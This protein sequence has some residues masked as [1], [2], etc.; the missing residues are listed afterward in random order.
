MSSTTAVES[1]PAECPASGPARLQLFST[2][3]SSS[4][5]GDDYKDRL[6]QVAK[7]SEQAGCT[8]SLIYTDNSLVDPWIV[9]QL[10][11]ENTRSL[12]PLIAVQPVYMHP[13]TVA[14]MVST[15]GKIHGRSVYLNMVAGGFRNDLAALN[16][17]TPHDRRYDR[18][19]EYTI[20]LQRLLA[21]GPPVTFAGEFYSVRNL[22]LNPSL[23]A[24]LAGG[25]LMSGSSDAGLAAARAIG[26]TAIRYPEPPESRQTLPRDAGPCGVRIGIIARPTEDEAWTVA[27]QRFPEDRKGRITRTLASQVSDSSWHKRLSEI[28]DAIAEQRQ[29]YWL[30]PFGN[31]HTNCPYLVG[32]YGNVAAE[33]ANYVGLGYRTFILDIPAAEE[34]FLHTGRVFELAMGQS[35][36]AGVGESRNPAQP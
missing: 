15:L 12:S 13:Y 2:C 28:T 29:T 11:I 26:A 36:A 10:V 19:V 34:E 21:G 7:W 6:I 22:S 18:L 35:L 1:H 16:D 5:H 20:I 9:S 14:K 25:I 4:Q 23:P 8:G 32:S 27:L 24:E 30:H 31:Y 17:A 3:P 33:V